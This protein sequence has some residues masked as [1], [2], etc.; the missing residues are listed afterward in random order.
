MKTALKNRLKRPLPGKAAQ[1]KM[2]SISRLDGGFEFPIPPHWRK[3]AVLCLLYPEKEDWHIALMQRTTNKNDKH[4]GQ[5][6]FPGG[7]HET[8]DASYEFTALRETEEEFGVPMSAVEILGELTP[9]PVPASSYMVFPFVGYCAKK[10]DFQPDARE[11]A[12]L[13]QPSLAQLQNPANLKRK[14]ISDP[15]GWSIKNV[16]YYDVNGNVVWGATAMI[17]T[18]FLDIIKEIQGSIRLV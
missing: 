1:Y 17:L 9:L 6:S 10:P 14:D 13:I 18:E 7:R 4:S 11:V 16:P 5:I 8:S 3:A 15:S 2:A 12:A